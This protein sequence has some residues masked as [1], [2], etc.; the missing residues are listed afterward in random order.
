MS[1]RKI[2]DTLS[3]VPLAGPAMQQVYKRWRAWRY[4][5]SRHLGLALGARDD[6][7]VLQIGSHDGATDD[8]VQ[9]QLALHTGWRALL[10]EPVPFVHERLRRK[11]EGDARI[12]TANVAVG[13]ADGTLPF[14]YLAPDTAE[15]VPGLP[16]YWDQLGSFNREHIINNFGDRVSAC[17]VEAAIS[18][19]TVTALLERHGIKKV[20][21]LHIDTEGADWMILRQFPLREFHPAI[22]IVEHKHLSAEDKRQ[23]RELLAAEYAVEDFGQ[24]YFCRARS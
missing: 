13:A 11:Y 9:R 24:D 1:L 2:K 18:T 3:S 8:P 16:H 5:P 17:I 21:V 6:V 22:I 20:D 15:R 10:V 7:Q 12:Q 23:M 4:D 14:Y 19:C